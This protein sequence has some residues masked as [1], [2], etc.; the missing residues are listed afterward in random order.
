M[1]FSRSAVA[2]GIALFLASAPGE[3]PKLERKLLKDRVTDLLRGYIVSGRIPAGTRLVERE[4]ANILGV[5]RVP[6]RDALIQL[7]KEGLIV[8]KPNGRYLIELNER[9]VREL[10]QVRRTLE[11]LAV[12]LAAQNTSP[13]NR[14]ILVAKLEELRAFAATGNHE[15]YTKSDVEMH[16]LVWQQAKNHHLFEV[17]SSMTGPLFM[18]AACNAETFDREETLGLHED[19]VNCINSGDPDAAV[20]SIERHLEQSLRRSLFVFRESGKSSQ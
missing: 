16:R 5:S 10:H 7:E 20:R 11:K 2:N 18:F 17:L 12:A 3:P 1:T 4:L 15:N 14:A 19:L 6:V 13:D 9:D 8:T